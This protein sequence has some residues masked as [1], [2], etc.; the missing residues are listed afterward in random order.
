MYLDFSDSHN[1]RLRKEARL[2]CATELSVC[3][4][5]EVVKIANLHRSVRNTWRF[6]AER[7]SSMC[8][9]IWNSDYNTGAIRILPPRCATESISTRHWGASSFTSTVSPEGIVEIRR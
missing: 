6:T 5:A 4:D 1:L 9:T 3:S 8:M 2:T 7:S